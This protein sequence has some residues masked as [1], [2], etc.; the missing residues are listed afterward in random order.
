MHMQAVLEVIM[1]GIHED[2]PGVP[3]PPTCTWAGDELRDE[4]AVLVEV[5]PT[6]TGVCCITLAM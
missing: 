5:R 2:R 3:E 4:L 6:H 1:P